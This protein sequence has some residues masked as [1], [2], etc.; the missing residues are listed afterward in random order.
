MVLLDYSNLLDRRITGFVAIWHLQRT[1]GIAS[2]WNISGDISDDDH[3]FHDCRLRTVAAVGTDD[4]VGHLFYRRVC[5]VDI[6]R[7]KS[8][9]LCIDLEIYGCGY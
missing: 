3:G 6:L 7:N 5:R 8:D 9:A 1:V 4:A 2:V